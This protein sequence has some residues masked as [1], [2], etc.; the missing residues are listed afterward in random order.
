LQGKQDETLSYE[1][2]ELVYLFSSSK[3]IEIP[4]RM[5]HATIIA[6][7]KPICFLT[8]SNDLQ[9]QEIAAVYQRRWDIEFGGRTP[10]L[11]FWSKSWE[12]V[13]FWLEMKMD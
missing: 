4:L 13:I 6:S 12:L 2:D 10:F 1:K 7:G 5:I 9:A 3:K 11:N 8:N